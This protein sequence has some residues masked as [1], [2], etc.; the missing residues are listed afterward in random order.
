MVD[1][2][3]TFAVGFIAGIYYVNNKEIIKTYIRNKFNK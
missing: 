2:I 1:F 3:I